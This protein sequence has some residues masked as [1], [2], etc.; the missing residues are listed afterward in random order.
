MLF[1]SV[2]SSLSSKYNGI[3]D[4]SMQAGWGDGNVLGAC[5]AG[6]QEYKKREGYDARGGE[7][8]CEKRRLKKHD[9]SSHSVFRTMWADASRGSEQALVPHPWPAPLV[10]ESVTQSRHIVTHI[11][12]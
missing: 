12:R 10:R 11:V 2:V 6:G 1:R 4:L 9:P 7:A 8:M 3:A 5:K